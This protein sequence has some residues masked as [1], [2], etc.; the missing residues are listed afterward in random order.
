MF[1]LVTMTL[2]VLLLSAC[3]TVSQY[4]VSESEIEKSLYTLLEQ[5]MP[6]L[7][8]GLVETQIDKLDLRIG[9]DNRDIVQLDLSGETAINAL[10]ARFPAKLDLVVEGRPVYDRQ[11][12]AIF[13]R[14]LNLLQSKVDAFGYKGDMTAAST[15]MMQ[16]LRSI[17]E[18][19]PVYR[20]ND[21][22]YAWISKAPVAMSIA[23]G[24]FVFS[25][26]FGD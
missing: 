24:R 18:N 5:Q 3:A 16:V 2:G 13:L 25:P 15:G 6:N 11:Q 17:L 14:D 7:T 8:Q 23:P 26:R 21:T 19:Q 10:I 1:K 22:K 9:P 12:N 4:N 20:L